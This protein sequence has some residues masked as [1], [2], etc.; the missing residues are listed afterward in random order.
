L[1]FGIVYFL[2]RGFGHDMA[3]IGAIFGMTVALWIT[4]LIP[5]AVSSLL[6]TTLLIVIGGVPEKTAF[7]AFGDPII[8]LFIGSFLLAKAMDLCG[9]SR[10][11]AYIILRMR[12]AN[13][14]AIGLMLALGVVSASISLFVSNTATTAMMLPIGL[15]VLGAL[16]E[17]KQGS[18]YAIGAMLMLTWGSSVA[19]GSPVSTPPNLIGISLIDQ[20]TGIRLSFVEWMRFAMPITVTVLV[21]AWGILWLL[22][23]RNAPS[24]SGAGNTASVALHDLGPMKQSEKSVLAAFL[25][26]FTLWVTPDVLQGVLGQEHPV[27]AWA[28]ANVTTAVSAIVAASLLFLLPARDRAGGKALN[29]MEGTKIDWGTILLFGG[30]IAL[31]QALFQSGLAREMGDLAA[32][33]SGAQSMWAITALMIVSAIILSELAS[34][35]ASA[36]TL[37]PVAIG[38]AEGAG[39]NPIAPALGAAIGASF[40]F[41][42]PVSTAPNAIVYS[43]GLVP[44]REMMKAG[45]I[46]DVSSAVVIWVMLRLFLPPLG[47]A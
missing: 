37:V 1:A 27:A 3:V 19:V 40:G 16:D 35:T 18:R 30:G 42:L 39:V 29:W 28:K 21:M 24:T 8:P 2:L 6:A 38:L 26:A 10:R 4:E 45:I 41:M 46:L 7:G 11:F 13:R 20:A 33:I 5:L 22:Y 32:Q 23:G 31:G 36:T 12:W 43:S 17:Q 15:A 14:S 34:N 9:L 44:P 47:L 25:V